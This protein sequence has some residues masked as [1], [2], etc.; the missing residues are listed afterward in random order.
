MS[1]LTFTTRFL[2]SCL[3]SLSCFLI[4]FSLTDLRL[5][6]CPFCWNYF[7]QVRQ[8]CLWILSRQHISILHLVDLSAALGS[9]AC[10]ASLSTFAPF[11]MHASASSLLPVRRLLLPPLLHRGLFLCPPFKYERFSAFRRLPVSAH[12]PCLLWTILPHWFF[13]HGLNYHQMLVIPQCLLLRQRG[14]RR[15]SLCTEC[16]SI[17][18]VCDLFTPFR[19]FLCLF[20]NEWW[21][22]VFP[23]EIWWSCMK[24]TILVIC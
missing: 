23:Q 19:A 18:E 3:Y 16:P 20:P 1:H 9:L 24:V 4:S 2:K 11:T 10:S 17:L 12:F 8:R 15:G 6:P 14:F 7:C 21:K 5:L 22:P 13:Q